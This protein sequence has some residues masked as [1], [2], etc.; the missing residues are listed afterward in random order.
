LSGS[1]K[2]EAH[3]MLKKKHKSFRIVEENF[4]KT[5]TFKNIGQLQ[6]KYGVQFWNGSKVNLIFM[7]TMSV[8]IFNELWSNELQKNFSVAF[9][10]LNYTMGNFTSGLLSFF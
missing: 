10:L 3:V 8:C 5:K 4:C 6:L 9:T 1:A 2:K 7:V